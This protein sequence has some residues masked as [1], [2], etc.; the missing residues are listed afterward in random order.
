MNLFVKVNL[1]I[2]F[3]RCAYALLR[4]GVEL[5][6]LENATVI[7][8]TGEVRSVIETPLLHR[9]EMYSV[10]LNSHCKISSRQR[11]NDSTTSIKHM[12]ALDLRD[13]GQNPLN[14]GIGNCWFFANS[15]CVPEKAMFSLGKIILNIKSDDVRFASYYANKDLT[16]QMFKQSHLHLQ[17]I[18]DTP[19]FGHEKGWLAMPL[20]G[21]Y[22]SDTISDA[23]DSDSQV[24]CA[25][26]T[27]GNHEKQKMYVSITSSSLS[28]T[29]LNLIFCQ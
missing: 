7:L 10:E 14:V 12:L 23:Q 3:F 15:V 18:G 28:H 25:C 20:E 2:I 17:S 27:V 1:S 24:Q 22:N 9:V 26:R 8:A 19:M 4:E 11:V 13:G 5:T 6:I 29:S 21:Y 16:P